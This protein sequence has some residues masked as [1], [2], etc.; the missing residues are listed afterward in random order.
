MGGFLLKLVSKS[1][2]DTLK[3]PPV[4]SFFDFKISNIYGKEIDF[5]EFRG[6]KLIMVVNVACK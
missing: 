3:T 1:G 2:V 6:K 4:K 5:N